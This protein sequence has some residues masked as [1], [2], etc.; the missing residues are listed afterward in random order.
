MNRRSSERKFPLRFL[1]TEKGLFKSILYVS[2]LRVCSSPRT[3][4]RDSILGI[5]LFA[6][7]P[8]FLVRDPS[9]TVEFCRQNQNAGSRALRPPGF[10]KA[11]EHGRVRHCEVTRKQGRTHFLVGSVLLH[12]VS[13]SPTTGH[14]YRGKNIR[15]ADRSQYDSYYHEHV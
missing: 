15:F 7:D 3:E 8:Q 9:S 11:I 5:M 6:S 12:P 4:G 13:L 14:G 1:T 2:E 10:V